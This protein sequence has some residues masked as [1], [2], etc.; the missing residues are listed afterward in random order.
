M[1]AELGA[2][3][4]PAGQIIVGFAA[5]TDDA[6]AHGREKLVAKGAD[7]LVVN[8][9]GATKGFEVADNAATILHADGGS[10]DVPTGP[11]AALADVVWDLVVARLAPA[12][13]ST[14][15]VS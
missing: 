1:L 14:P 4:R 13:G 2:D 6:L 10:T 7:L 15:N 8:E 5:E 9:V 12:H 3:A 11:K